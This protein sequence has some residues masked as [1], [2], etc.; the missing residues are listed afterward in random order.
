MATIIESNDE[1][2]ALPPFSIYLL[3]YIAL[4]HNRFNYNLSAWD[5]RFYCR[6]CC[7]WTRGCLTTYWETW[8]TLSHWTCLRRRVGPNTDSPIS[9]S[10][11]VARLIASLITQDTSTGGLKGLCLTSFGHFRRQETGI[12][13]STPLPSVCSRE[14]LTDID[15]FSMGWRGGGLFLPPRSAVRRTS[16]M[17]ILVTVLMYRLSVAMWGYQDKSLML[18]SRLHR[19]LQTESMSGPLYRRWRWQQ[20]QNNKEVSVWS[21]SLSR[22]SVDIA[23]FAKIS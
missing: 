3:H 15:K 7:L 18:R 16:A 1:K 4:V 13:F 10:R 22:L 8:S 23:W 12:V 11:S 9:K 2:L 19:R 6:T 20:A 21:F 14:T 17:E 5:T